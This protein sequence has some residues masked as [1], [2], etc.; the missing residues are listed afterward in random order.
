M[1]ASRVKIAADGSLRLPPDFLEKLGWKTGNYLE[2]TVED[3]AV[4][5]RHVEVDLFAE[6]LKK[7]DPDTL[8]KLLEKQRR[9]QQDA[10]KAFEE[11]LKSRDLPEARPEDR[12]DYWR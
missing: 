6:A 8:E 12:P 3:G 4:R 10:V 7:P 1:L 5:L 11:K 9:S 2:A